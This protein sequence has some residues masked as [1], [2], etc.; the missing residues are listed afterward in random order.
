MFEE[1][2]NDP[3]L[4]AIDPIKKYRETFRQSI[5]HTMCIN[6]RVPMLEY[7]LQRKVGDIH[8]L[9]DQGR[10]PFH[11]AVV[12]SLSSSSIEALRVLLNA[13]A[14]I[15][16]KDVYNKTAYDYCLEV[17]PEEVM[18]ATQFV[19]DEY[20]KRHNQELKELI[21]M[22]MHTEGRLKEPFCYM[23]DNDIY[24]VLELL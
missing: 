18:V 24:R 6:D 23:T 12:Q 4:M 19:G 1:R 14:N 20:N 5:L 8:E 7:L 16:M 2:A 9:D 13:G 21:Y 15:L 10:P 22:I 11:V 17:D 3:E